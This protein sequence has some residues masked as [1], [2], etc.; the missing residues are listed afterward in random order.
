[1]I[2]YRDSTQEWDR[3]WATND[4]LTGL[5]FR[6]GGGELQRLVG[7]GPKAFKNE[8]AFVRWCARQKKL[9]E[10]SVAAN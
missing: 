9:F 7:P 2:T 6:T 8:V 3:R 4:D 1:M 5:F 10:L